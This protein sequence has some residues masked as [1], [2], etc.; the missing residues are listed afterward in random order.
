[1][2]GMHWEHLDHL[3]G[4]TLSRKQRDWVEEPTSGTLKEKLKQLPELVAGRPL[5]ASPA[6]SRL[7]EDAKPFRDA[8]MHPAPFAAPP[9]FGGY[10]K[11]SHFC[12]ID[13]AL[14]LEIVSDAVEVLLELT[15]HVARPTPK[16]L[17]D[18]TNEVRSP[19]ASNLQLGF[20][21]R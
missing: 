16:W 1:M 4:L 2:G 17:T 20:I 11:L 8:L 19:A 15:Q 21:S 13:Q 3:K 18:L 12:E 10:N 6:L 9:K 7:M 5:P 14:A